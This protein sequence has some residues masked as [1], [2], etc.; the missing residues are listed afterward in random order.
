MRNGV[1]QTLH[2]IV[3]VCVCE[4]STH[5]EIH[6][7]RWL[8]RSPVIQYKTDGGELGDE[9]GGV[10]VGRVEGDVKKSSSMFPCC[11]VRMDVCE[12]LG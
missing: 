10:G 6:L 12:R 4:T 8:V 3:A 9:E 11:E 1:T 5:T 7:F 2:Y